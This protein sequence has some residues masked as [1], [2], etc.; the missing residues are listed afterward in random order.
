MDEP[1]ELFIHPHTNRTT[2]EPYGPQYLTTISV[3]FISHKMAQGSNMAFVHNTRGICHARVPP[4]VSSIIAHHVGNRCSP[5]DRWES[6]HH[7]DRNHRRNATSKDRLTCRKTFNARP[8]PFYDGQK[9]S[10]YQDQK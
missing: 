10:L 1:I 4:M 5:G 3:V 9:L 6:D 8:S 2:H 7:P